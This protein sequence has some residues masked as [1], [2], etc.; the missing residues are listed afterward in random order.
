MWLFILVS[1]F[2]VFAISPS[3]AFIELQVPRL[4]PATPTEDGLSDFVQ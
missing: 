4:T 3:P 2:T 1:L